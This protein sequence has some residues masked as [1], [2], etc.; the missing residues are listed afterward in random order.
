MTSIQDAVNE[1]AVGILNQAHHFAG[2]G[3]Y[4]P[5]FE[6][7]HARFPPMTGRAPGSERYFEL[8]ASGRAANGD[9]SLTLALDLDTG[10]DG[11]AQAPEGDGTPA[12]G[13]AVLNA[14][15]RV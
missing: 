12:G 2:A 13:L 7:P 4:I 11:R 1:P 5:F 6:F 9:R 8:P 3:R 10:L 14:G 15:R